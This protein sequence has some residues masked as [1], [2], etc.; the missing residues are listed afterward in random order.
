MIKKQYVKSRDVTKLTFRLESGL[1]ADA[2]HLLA[3]F[4]DW[5][6]VAFDRLKDGSW[7]LVQEVQP[8]AS[9]QFRYKVLHGDH[10]HYL[11]DPEADAVVPND[12]GTE[13]AVVQA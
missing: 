1:D 10:A 3:E 13:N 7:K 12:Q 2:V 9:Y 5:R 11:N 6:P 4:N 8:G